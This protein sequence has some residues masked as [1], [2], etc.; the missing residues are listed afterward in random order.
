MDTPLR[1]ARRR[2]WACV[3]LHHIGDLR[4]FQPLAD[5]YLNASALRHAPVSC[6]LQHT[7]VHKCLG[8]THQGDKSKALLDIQPFDDCF[9]WLCLRRA[10]P[11]IA[12]RPFGYSILKGVIVIVTAAFWFA[13]IFVAAHS[14]SGMTR[15]NNKYLASPRA[16]SIGHPQNGRCLSLSS[17]I[18]AAPDRRYSPPPRRSTHMSAWSCG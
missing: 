12:R 16:Q 6:C 4:A 10:R 1:R 14:T 5:L 17:T 15:N 18:V 9:D 13:V 11:W 8:S 3:Q 2:N 7:D